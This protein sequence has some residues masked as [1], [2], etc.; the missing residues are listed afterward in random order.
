M[1]KSTAVRC[2]VA[3]VAAFCALEAQAEFQLQEATI[4]GIHKAIRDGEITCKQVVEAYVARARAYNGTCTSS[5]PTDGAKMPQ[6]LGAVR[7]GSPVKF[8]TETVALSKI[9]PDFDKYTG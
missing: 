8:P 7:A 4:D 6:V 5:S 1:S 9:V 3:L 2:S